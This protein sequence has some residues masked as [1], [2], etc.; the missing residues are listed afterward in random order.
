[1]KYIITFF[2]LLGILTAKSQNDEDSNCNALRAEVYSGKIKNS[3]ITMQLYFSGDIIFGCYF[4][5]KYG[6]LIPLSGKR[7]GLNL[8]LSTNYENDYGLENQVKE[9][10]N[11]TIKIDKS[12]NYYSISGIWSSEDKKFNFSATRINTKI[13]WRFFSHKFSFTLNENQNQDQ[14]DYK[15]AVYPIIPSAPDLSRVILSKILEGSCEK[16]TTYIIS[17][18][19]SN[20]KIEKYFNDKNFGDEFLDYKLNY[21]DCFENSSIGRVWYYNDSLISYRIKNHRYVINGHGWDDSY[22]YVFK[23]NTGEKVFLKDI[24]SESNYKYILELLHKK[25]GIEIINEDGRYTFFIGNFTIAPGGIYFNSQE[26]NMCSDYSL[27]LSYDE[28]SQYI[29]EP[30]QYLTIK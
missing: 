23:T 2:I 27:F 30:F 14:V 19:C 6:Q 13:K 29:N 8:T 10:F 7:D 24:I 4:Y 5:N 22:D 11:G 15:S 28:I 1:M 9:T 20:L 12:S 3:E 18:K 21:P 26:C 16:Y 25:Y 17:S